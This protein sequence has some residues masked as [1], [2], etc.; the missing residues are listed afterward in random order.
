MPIPQWTPPWPLLPGRSSSKDPERKGLIAQQHLVQVPLEFTVTPA[1]KSGSSDIRLSCNY[2]ILKPVASIIQ[3]IY[4]S[5]E[6]YE[7]RNQQLARFGY[8]AYSLS[9]IPYILMSLINLLANLCEPQYPSMFLVNYGGPE[10]T[11]V[12]QLCSG[13]RDLDESGWQLGSDTTAVDQMIQTN[14]TVGGIGGAVGTA[15]GRFKTRHENSNAPRLKVRKH[16]PWEQQ[17][18]S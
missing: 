8:A 15:Y 17:I 2:S 3:I 11:S 13:K 6:L 4:G 16:L 9:L 1:V 18:Y 12:E 7:A 10:E 5:F 14:S